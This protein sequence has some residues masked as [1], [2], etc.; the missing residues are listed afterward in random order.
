MH[1]IISVENLSKVYPLYLDKRDRLYEALDPF[2]RRRHTDFYALRDVSFAVEQGEC[3]GVIGVNGS[4]KSTLL[5]ILTGVLT[6]TA[7]TVT[8]HGRV[9]ALLELG[10]GFHPERTG[11]DNVRFQGVVQGL[12]KEE[13]DSYLPQ[14]IEFA[15]IGDFINQPVKLY[16]SGMFVR[17]AFAAAIQGNPDILI[18]DEALAVGDMAFQFKCTAKIKSMIAHGM[19]VLFVSHDMG[20]VKNLCQRCLY[21]S[22]G[23]MKAIGPAAEIGDLY[24]REQREAYN[25]HA[26]FFNS[27]P[28]TTQECLEQSTAVAHKTDPDFKHKVT[29][30]GTGD[31]Q[32]TCVEL[33]DFQGIPLTQAEFDQQIIIRLHLVFS[34][35]GQTHVGYHIRNRLNEE[36]LGTGTGLEEFAPLTGRQGDR[37]VVDF[38]TKIPLLEG[39]YAIMAVAT[40]RQGEVVRFNDIVENAAVFQM[41]ARQ[42]QKIWNAVYLP[43][44]VAVHYAGCEVPFICP[45][46]SRQHHGYLPLSKDLE[47]MLAEYGFD[48]LA[49]R[50]EFYNRSKLSCPSCGGMD[51]ERLSAEYLLRRLGAGFTAPE[52]RFLEFAPNPAFSDFLQRHFTFRHE[53]ADLLRPNVDHALDLTNM[54]KIAT[55]SVDAWVSLHMLEHIPDDAAALRELHRILKPG[56]FGILLVPLSLALEKTDE[57]PEAP[58]EE[59]WRRFGQ[60]DHIRMYAKRDFVERIEHTGFTLL[61]LDQEWFGKSC[62]MRLGLPDTAT[63]YVVEKV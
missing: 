16:S 22:K 25:T 45:L 58:V 29:R 2:R 26:D 30:Q 4:G 33:L 61:M 7:G 15:D 24:L 59:R 44:T 20:S 53:T 37:F 55:E 57:D 38:T 32:F 46:C 36:I 35:A 18:V 19:T 49:L 43:N 50:P 9:S 12:Q 31:I 34:T 54:P 21:L 52:F 63:L 23:A 10:A 41:Q 56:G 42:P 17:L 48:A 8:M 6:P 3:L 47:S 13:I 11:I 1:K 62:F 51:R 27:L 40:I 5:K 28:E 60:D 39:P 14:V